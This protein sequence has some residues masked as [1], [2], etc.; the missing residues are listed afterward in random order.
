MARLLPPQK[1]GIA[2]TAARLLRVLAYAP[3]YNPAMD[4]PSAIGARVTRLDSTPSTMD[5]AWDLADKGAPHGAV[6]VARAQTAGRGRF[7][8]EWV[9]GDGE[10]LLLSALL[11]PPAAAAPLLSPAA[12]LAALDAA[13]E[14]AGIPCDLKWP[15]DV[16]A[17]GR[18]AGGILI[19][20]RADVDGAIAA[21]IGVGLNLNIDFSQRPDLRALRESATSLAEKAGRRLDI[22]AAESV[23]LARL[24]ERYRQCVENSQSLLAEWAARLSTIGQRVTVRERDGVV[25]GI[26]EGVDDGGRLIVRTDSGERKALSEGDVTLAGGAGSARE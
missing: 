5:A 12:A 19:E 17:A 6:V 26:A 14:I 22:R 15:N 25:T 3:R 20:I 8:R 18:K 9:S 24:R 16:M 1:R 7:S 2:R 10:S 21:V 23:F 13:E 11:R 4:A